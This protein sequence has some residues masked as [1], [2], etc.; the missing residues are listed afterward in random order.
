LLAEA[1]MLTAENDRKRI[2]LEERRLI[3]EEK[4]LDIH[5]QLITVLKH[6][7]GFVDKCVFQ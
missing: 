7:Q 3:I 4:I 2:S 6:L 5:E 1:A